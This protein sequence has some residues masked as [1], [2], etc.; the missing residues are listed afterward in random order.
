MMIPTYVHAGCEILPEDVYYQLTVGDVFNPAHCLASFTTAPTVGDE[1]GLVQPLLAGLT[2]YEV[3]GV[4]DTMA[5]IVRH[6]PFVKTLFLKHK[7]QEI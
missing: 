2:V 6:S 3:V 1:I 5:G 4:Q 7:R